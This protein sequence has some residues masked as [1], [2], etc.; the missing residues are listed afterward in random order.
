M[1][2]AT[3]RYLF[4]LGIIGAAVFISGCASDFGKACTKFFEP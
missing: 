4:L 2:K 1:R 3:I